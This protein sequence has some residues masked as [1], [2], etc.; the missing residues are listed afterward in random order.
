M[1]AGG[2]R[3]DRLP[4]R[5]SGELTHLQ[6]RSLIT[7]FQSLGIMGKRGVTEATVILNKMV[8]LDYW[9][10]SPIRWESIRNL[11]LNDRTNQFE[12]FEHRFETV[13]RVF[14]SLAICDQTNLPKR[15]ETG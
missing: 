4:D 6:G 12:G 13:I 10:D 8:D 9:K 7:L 14:Y 3:V 2:R 15:A 11:L 1:R 5:Y